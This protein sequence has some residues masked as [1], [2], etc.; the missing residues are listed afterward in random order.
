V[1]GLAV[2]RKEALSHF[3]SHLLVKLA[4]LY[5]NRVQ[6]RGETKTKQE[7]LDSY[8]SARAFSSFILTSSRIWF[9]KESRNCSPLSSLD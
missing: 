7:S 3:L 6:T 4:V 1:N 8:G 2:N 5:G 9:S